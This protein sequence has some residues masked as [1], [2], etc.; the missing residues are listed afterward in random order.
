MAVATTMPAMSQSKWVYQ[1]GLGGTLNS[2]NINNIGFRNTGSIDRNDSVL[3]FSTSYRFLY[4]EE[5]HVT[6]NMGLDGGM[7][8]DYMQYDRWSP[9]CAMEFISNH[10]KGYDFKISFLAGAKYRIY[11]IPGRCDYSISAALVGDYANY[12]ITDPIAD[13]LDR[14]LMRISLR[15]KIVQ[16][17]GESTMLK[18][19]TFYQPSIIDYSD[20][21]ISSI[22]KVENK[23]NSHLFL[24]IIFE[25]DYRSVV[26]EERS[27]YDVATEI[28]LRLKF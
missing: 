24:D 11:T 27:R 22:T 5:N 9:F 12:H 26:P 3:A 19:M 14:V 21:I 18:H 17:I 8:L 20:F 25:Y 2:G 7:K 16:R 6:T 28:A 15:G 4:S 13:T 10:F 23:L 1:L